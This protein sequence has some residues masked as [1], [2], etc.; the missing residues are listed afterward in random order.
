MTT[1]GD[2]WL[3]IITLRNG[4]AV[5]TELFFLLEHRRVFSQ[6]RIWK[7][8]YCYMNAGVTKN[9]G[10]DLPINQTFFSTIKVLKE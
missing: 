3:A 7:M 5:G 10:F 6:G 9:E 4:E 2:L 8:H 1:D